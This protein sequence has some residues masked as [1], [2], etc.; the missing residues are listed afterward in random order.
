MAN[1]TLF[2]KRRFGITAIAIAFCSVKMAAQTVVYTK[3]SYFID[4]FTALSKYRQESLKVNHIPLPLLKW[5]T[6]HVELLRVPRH[7]YDSGRY[8]YLSDLI[9]NCKPRDAG[10]N[11]LPGADVADF[12]FY[13]HPDLIPQSWQSGPNEDP[14]VVIF[15]GTVFENTLEDVLVRCFVFIWS[16]DGGHWDDQLRNV[17]EFAYPNVAVVSISR[18]M[19][20]EAKKSNGE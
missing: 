15:A 4:N 13:D 12:L 11:L 1:L 5:D 17:N 18:K 3:E 19:T 2:A 14:A 6:A 8:V 16:D 10:S 9:Y 20:V 7:V